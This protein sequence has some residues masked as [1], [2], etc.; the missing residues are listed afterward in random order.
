MLLAAGCDVN[1]KNADGRTPLFGVPCFSDTELAVACISI[2]TQHGAD[3]TVRDIEGD[4]PLHIM[5]SNTTHG[6]INPLISAGNDI[7]ACRSSDVRTLLM[8][9][10]SPYQSNISSD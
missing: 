10:I 9:A 5:T 2:L 3:A 4:M 8:C 1:A 6:V 7:N